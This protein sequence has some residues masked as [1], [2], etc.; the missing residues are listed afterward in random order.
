MLIGFGSGLNCTVNRDTRDEAGY[1][2]KKN[3]KKTKFV[4]YRL[5]S[6]GLEKNCALGL[7]CGPWPAAS[8]V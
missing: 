7:E 5:W 4:I 6:V 3:T 8:D 2:F 1:Y